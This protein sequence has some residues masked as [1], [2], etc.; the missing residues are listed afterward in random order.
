MLINTDI[1]PTLRSLKP[2]ACNL[3]PAFGFSL[4]EI[5][6]ALGLFAFVAISLLGLFPV[7]Q[8]ITADSHQLT[9]APLIVQSILS[10]LQVNT[11][12]G[13]IA[14]APDWLSNPS[15][16]LHFSLEQSSKH[17]VAYNKQ[18]VPLRLLTC[19][20][21]EAPLTHDGMSYA[22]CITTTSEKQPSGIVRVEVIITSPVN[23]PIKARNHS[24]FLLLLSTTT[25]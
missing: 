13:I 9:E 11:P 12:E 8:R 17:Y 19:Q 4:L 3:Q 5:V 10:L 25:P 18:G 20:E 1:R 16:C 7:A 22:V 15:H 6:V 14:T 2:V 21:Y 24:E 23:L